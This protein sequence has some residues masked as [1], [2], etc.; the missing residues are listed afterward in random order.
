MA[1]VERNWFRRGMAQEDGRRWSTPTTGLEAPYVPGTL[2]SRGLRDLAGEIAGP[3]LEPSI[4]S[5]DT[6]VTQG[7]RTGLQFAALGLV[8]MIEEYARHN[9]HADLLREAIDGVTGE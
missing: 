9:G 7:P 6:S 1:E 5:L 8:H 2:R 3:A 4:P